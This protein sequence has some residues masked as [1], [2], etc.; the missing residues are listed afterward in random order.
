MEIEPLALDGALLIRGRRF[1]DER[2]WFEETWSEARLRAAGFDRA[3]VQDNLAY[4]ARAGTLRGL[5]CQV[6]PSAQ[7]KLIGVVT[8]A[9]RD[10]IVDVRAGSPTFGRHVVMELTASDP[11]RLWAPPGFL[12][13]FVTLQ[14]DTR[15][16]YKVTAAYDASA[17][18]AIVWNDP[19]LAIDWGV[20]DPILSPKDAHAPRLR[21]AGVLFEQAVW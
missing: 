11:V 4:S 6:S 3:F 9:V 7:G 21:D 18:R 14:P 2:G 20:Q 10:V 15:V 13:G 19:D 8:G 12:H 17:D 16:A 5:H 1:S